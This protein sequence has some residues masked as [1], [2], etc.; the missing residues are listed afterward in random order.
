[1]RCDESEKFLLP[2]CIA[3]ELIPL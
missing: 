1:M 3:T 2:A